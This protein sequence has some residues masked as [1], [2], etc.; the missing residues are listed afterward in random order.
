MSIDKGVLTS[1]TVS[2][3]CGMHADAYASQR[4]DRR[5]HVASM[6]NALG[7]CA[8]FSAQVAVW[9]E[10]ILS[11]N[12]N[13]GDFLFY[14]TT[15]T[16]ENFIFGEPINQFLFLIQPD[17]LSF[18]RLPAATLQNASEFPNIGELLGHVS[19]SIG[20]EAFGKPRPP[21]SITLPDLPRDALMMAW[22]KVAQILEGARHAEWPALMG[23]AAYNII[24]ANR[25]V[26]APSDALKILLEAAAPMSKL[27][28]ETVAQSGIAAPFQ[29]RWSMR[30]LNDFRAPSSEITKEIVAE[31]RSVM[32]AMPATIS[33]K[34]SVI[35]EPVIAFLNL[36]GA[37]ADAFL[38]EDRAAIGSL[39]P[40]AALTSDA[41][42]PSCDVLFL[43]C[44]V[45]PSGQVAG[46]Q[47][48]MRDLIGKSGATIAI[49]ASEVPGEIVIAPEF[50][51]VIARGNNA[52][53]NMIITGNRNGDSFSR[54]FRALFELMFQG[55]H[56]PWAWHLLAPQVPNQPEDLP[57]TI[58]IFEAGQVMF[59]TEQLW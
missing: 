40:G 21:V 2:L 17:R 4:A 26:L 36:Q 45:E 44:T 50:Q 9:C 34:P 53:V 42:V 6:L 33:A 39:F 12:R 7:A 43:Y 14:T 41:S 22:P 24:Y 56:M 32:P 18:L 28:P 23:A 8:G 35:S 3:L 20:T 37:G 55:E 38:A 13:P 5:G 16:N 54:F 52:P 49:I 27:N 46:Q 19:S 31:V 11:K 15:K 25:K 48:S 57:G 51:K 59:G 1:K 10:L 47:C 29:A 30:A 58:C